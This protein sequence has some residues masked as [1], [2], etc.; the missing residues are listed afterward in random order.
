MT[1]FAGDDVYRVDNAGDQVIEVIGGGTDAVEATASWAMA[2]G[3]EIETLRAANRAGTGAIDLTG[4]AFNNAL[5]GNAGAN[6]LDGGG[7][8]DVLTGYEGNDI[9][10]VDDAGDRV[11]ERVRGGY[12]TV[13]ASVSWALGSGQEVEVLS[14]SSWTRTTAI[15]LTGNEFANRLFGN[16][17]SNFLDGGAGADTMTGFA[18]NDFYNVDDLGDVVV[19][20]AGG[21]YDTVYVSTSW[22][23]S[24]NAAVEVISAANWRG[25]APLAITGN[26]VANQLFGNAGAN[27]LNGGGGNDL[28]TGFGGA[29]RFVFA[30]VL[31]AG[32]VDTV[33]DFETGT[34]RI[35]LDRSVFSGLLTGTLSADAF[36]TGPV[37]ID[38][39]DRIL[40]DPQSG[41]LLFD[42][43]G[44]GGLDAVV[45]ATLQGA[46][47]LTPGDV[48]VI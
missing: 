22:T 41:A 8:A 34:D 1:G 23:L 42:A 24:E 15:D 13:Y 30:T 12:D 33:T 17:G 4:N 5:L 19:E 31:S 18:G 36:R 7:G 26:N 47:T 46:A 27:T 9:F 3:M 21:G 6:T 32:N 16:A 20:A 35:V 28:L 11:V 48:V 38:A 37:A 10:G 14:T 25:T 45:F 2:A 44:A 43:D 39:D 29:D 40:Y